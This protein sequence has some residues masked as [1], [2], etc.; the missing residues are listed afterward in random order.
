MKMKKTLIGLVAAGIV[1]VCAGTIAGTSAS[2]EIV[3]LR[4]DLNQDS[5][6]SVSDVVLLQ[7][8]MLGLQTAN[9]DE[10]VIDV[11]QDG[12]VNG[13]DLSLLRQM[14]C[15]QAQWSY[16]EV[17]ETTTTE[18]TTTTT[19]ETTTT[20]TTTTT[21]ST[22]TTTEETTTTEAITT[23][24][25]TT[26]STSAEA[27][28][29]SESVSQIGAS[30]GSK[31][32][33]ALVIFYV[34]FPDCKY[35]TE[36][37]TSELEEIAFG[38]EDTSDVN[39]PFESMSAFFERSSKGTM[40]LTGKVFR[41]TTSENQ[42]AY[43]NDKGKLEK[44]CYEAF[45][46]QVDFSDYDMDNDGYIDC[47]LFTVP[48][49]AGDDNWWPCAGASSTQSSEYQWDNA[50]NSWKLVDNSY[51]VDGEKI[52]HIITG[53]ADPSDGS[54]YGTGT[55]NFNSSYLHEMGHC[56]GLPDYYLYSYDSTT[57]DCW[58]FH[59]S[60][61]SE[62][63]DDATSDMG[64]FSKLMLGWYKEDQVNVYKTTDGTKTYTLYN[65][66]TDDGNCVI[67]PVNNTLDAQY[68]SEYFIIE[69]NT[70]TGNN[71]SNINWTGTKSGV[72]I[73][74]ISAE[75]SDNGYWK[76]YTYENGSE[77]NQSSSYG[78]RLL[79]LVNDG[80]G[81]FTSGSVIDNSVSGFG[82]YDSSNNE[83]VDPGV[84]ISVGT[85]ASGNY[86]VTITPKN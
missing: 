25:I 47:T 45:K 22:T 65:A 27:S 86:T 55:K 35:T 39:Y 14:V 38:P 60:A 53:N 51:T 8:S 77:L 29:I 12:R 44:E 18:A 81:P 73:F 61:A 32:D 43:D 72:R 17:A 74:H 13:M 57:E 71:S 79:R 48:V 49:G 24:E 34:D 11:N 4:G 52:G 85:D 40:H 46:D 58:G 2:A 23:T 20:T 9:C 62:L 80:N 21:T 68:N 54:V 56:M 28:F 3:G 69:Y 15:G 7:K 37:S 5:Y 36:Y 31:G 70:N 42:S 50:S 84:S 33:Q 41:Y 10:D 6:L 67:I 75:I 26:Q 63:M 76:Y 59:G 16:I 1:S 82:F 66:Q 19:E 64:A 30:L 78:R 83:T